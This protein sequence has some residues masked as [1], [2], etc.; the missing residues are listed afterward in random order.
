MI[1]FGLGKCYEYYP[2]D[3][4]QS[5]IPPLPDGKSEIFED[6]LKGV[7]TSFNPEVHFSDVIIKDFEI[8]PRRKEKN[9]E[10]LLFRERITGKSFV[11]QENG[12]P[13]LEYNAQTQ[14]DLEIEYKVNLQNQCQKSVVWFIGENTGDQY[15]KKIDCRKQWCP[16]CGGKGG[17][18][19]K[20][21]LHSIFNRFDVDKYN[22]RQ[23][24]FT[25]P[26]SLRELF[27]D[28]ENL[29][30]LI[31]YVKQ[32]IERFFGV[33]VFDKKGHIKKY[34]LEKG[35]IFYLHL[36]GDNEPGVYKPH[37]NVHIL[38]DKKEKLALD[39]SVLESIKKYYLRKIK[40]FDE[41]LTTVDVHYKFRITKGQVLHA[42]KYMSRPWNR[43]D[44]EA[45]KNENLK[46]LLVV[47]LNGFQ[48]LRFLGALSNCNYKD[49]MSLP[50]VQ[51]E[52]ESKIEE[53][54]MPVCISP[55]D[56]NKWKDSLVEIDDGFYR[57][58]KKG[59][60]NE[61]EKRKIIEEKENGIDVLQ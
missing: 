25:I 12:S 21:R 38:E 31:S 37:I 8:V 47:D 1:N 45:I 39:N 9:I 54:L 43:E 60:D 36:F 41:T 33:P 19:H 44:F 29:N 15:V 34:K 50:E 28:R 13:Y 32:T 10:K 42:L 46:K 11:E 49:E 61:P 7:I 30:L 18:I 2:L 20:S 27:L 16:V 14:G 59:L 35:I 40:K 26:E 4:K 55:F 17:T 6:D 3:K 57:I 53:K 22:L 23:F 51:A 48:Y 24:V 58:K 5:F 52:C 56:E